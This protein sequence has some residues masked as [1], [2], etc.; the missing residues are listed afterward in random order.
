MLIT[1]GFSQGLD[2]LCRALV[3]RGART[4]AVENPSLP[5]FWDTIRSWRLPLVADPIDQGAPRKDVLDALRTDAFDVS[6]GRK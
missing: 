3:A 1:Q 4:V 2:L 6:Q 5:T